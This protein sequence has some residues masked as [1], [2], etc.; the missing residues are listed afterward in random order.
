METDL[1]N[2]DEDAICR[3]CW[4]KENFQPAEHDT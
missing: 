3:D 2:D 4:I 1:F